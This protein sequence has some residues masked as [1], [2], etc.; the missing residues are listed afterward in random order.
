MKKILFLTAFVYASQL[1]FPMISATVSP[2]QAQ[3]EAPAPKP[4]P[5][6]KPESDLK[7]T[8]E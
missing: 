3:D 7:A 6:P 8:A 2:S 4:A 5:T 1:G